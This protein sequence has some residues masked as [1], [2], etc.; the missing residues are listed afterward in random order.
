MGVNDSM[1]GSGI[2]QTFLMLRLINAHQPIC[3]IRLWVTFGR[4]LIKHFTIVILDSRGVLDRKLFGLST[5]I[6][7]SLNTTSELY[8]VQFSSQ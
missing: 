3:Y 1:N 5:K 4:Q 8:C 6:V 7:R 2:N